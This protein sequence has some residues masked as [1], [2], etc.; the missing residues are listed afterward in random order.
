MNGTA[1]TPPAVAVRSAPLP[2]SLARFIWSTGL[3]HQI[4]LSVLSVAVFL[5]AAAP[6]EVQRRMVNDAYQGQDFGPILK[7]AIVYVAVALAE[8]LMKLGMN[9]YRGWVGESSVRILRRT[10][11][12]GQ[13]DA[14]ADDKEFGV[15]QLGTGTSM[16]LAEVEPI[17]GFVAVSLSEP[18]LQGG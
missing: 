15:A 12:A 9:I 7:L 11:N 2:P 18:V 3:R 17:A 4:V 1:A 6:L 16:M 14:S 5:L 13:R 10:V 8:G